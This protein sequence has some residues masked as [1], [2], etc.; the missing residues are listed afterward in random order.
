M[1]LDGSP[2][3][4]EKKQSA[5]AGQFNFAPLKPLQELAKQQK[6]DQ[7]YIKSPFSQ[8]V[9]EI[10]QEL[11]QSNIE[12]RREIVRVGQIMANLR[13]G[14]ETIKLNPN[15]GKFMFYK[16]LKALPTKRVPKRHKYPLTQVK[17]SEWTSSWT[18]SR[19]QVQVRNFG[20]TNE[21]KIQHFLV[22]QLIKTYDPRLFDEHFHQAQSLSMMDFGTTCIRI[23]YDEQHNPLHYLLPQIKQESQTVFEGYAFCNKCPNEGTPEDFTSASVMPRCPE[24][25]SYDVSEMYEPQNVDVNKIVG[26][27][28]HVQGDLRADLLEIPYCNFDMRYLAHDSDYFTYESPVYMSLVNSILGVDIEE[29]DENSDEFIKVVEQIATRGGSVDGIGRDNLEG[30]TDN[31]GRRQAK[32]RETWLKPNYYRGTKF[33]EDQ[34]TVSGEII[35]K[36]VPLEKYF[37][38]GMCI[39]SFNEGRI[40]VGIYN[41]KRTIFGG[42]YHIQSFSGYGKGTSDAIEINEQLDMAHTAALE[43]I[44]RTG[45]GGGFTYDSDAIS[46]AEAKQMIKPDGFVG[47]SLAG[48]NYTSVDQLIKQTRL[49]SVDPGNLTVVA[50][51][52]NLL[53][54]AFQST[55]FTSGTLNNVNVNT[56]GGQEMLSAQKMHLATAPLRMKGYTFAKVYQDGVIPL[57]RKHI[58]IPQFITTSDKFQIAKGKYISGD[59]LP[60]RIFCDFVPDTEVPTNNYSRKENAKSM[61]QESGMNLADFSMFME[62]K[63]NIASWWNDLFQTDLPVVNMIQDLMVCQDRLNDI[64][65][66]AKEAEMLMQASRFTPPMPEIMAAMFGELKKPVHIS[67]ENHIGKA[68]I[69]S[70]YLDDDA[71]LQ[72]SPL[73][74]EFIEYLINKHHEFAVMVKYRPVML[75][76]EMQM[77]MKQK[78][79][80]MQMQMQ[81]AMQPDPAE[82]AA[83]QAAG[84]LAEETQKEEDWKRDQ[85]A[86]EN[87][88]ERQLLLEK[89]KRKYDTASK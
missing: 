63:P 80:Q 45:A 70:S 88:L 10:E 46:K 83:Q 54:I 30:N 67:E 59:D 5:S 56:K 60:E 74:T 16:P 57:F 62:Q 86:K 79:A 28:Q 39:V 47:V 25:G 29:F 50:Q 42:V 61:L 43:Q 40:Q 33:S 23:S 14:K 31:Y 18:S 68:D 15:T 51:L 9:Y 34:E 21:A 6:P 13:S 76:H 11:S 24:C 12:A 77:Q 36:G 1:P 41:E 49:D 78:E 85:A 81:Q 55:D 69:L 72:W 20:D 66:L 22:Q 65:E 48:T 35:E 71:V 37:P 27:E 4:L 52:A 44:K 32:M 87:E 2:Y 3:K 7:A 84:L 75:E 82:V 26:M 8:W 19:P 58:K 89:G 73:V 38:D 64:I 17:S 53:N